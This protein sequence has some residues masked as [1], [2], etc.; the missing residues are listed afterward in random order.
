VIFSTLLRRPSAAP[1]RKKR[2]VLSD[3]GTLSVTRQRSRRYRI[4]VSSGLI[5]SVLLHILVVRLS[6][7]LVRYLED[8]AGIYRV[9]RPIIVEPR[10]MQAIEIRITEAPPVEPE[11]TPEPEPEPQAVEPEPEGAESSL[12]GAERLRPRVGDWR[13]WVV[14][15]LARRLDRT[16][17]E[18]N[19]ELEARLHAL[20]EAYDDSIAAEF[21]RAAESMDWTVGEEGN[22][23]G[24]SPQGL[25][26]GP[27]T[28]PLPFYIGPGRESEEMLRDYGAI[29]RQAGEDAIR[30][31]QKERIEAI[32]ER[33][34]QAR[35]EA[36]RNAQKDTTGTH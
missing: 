3:R 18:R 32:R 14:P 28:L 33:N 24:V 13:L 22:K 7:L 17:E 34:R 36:Q 10:G 9:P 6:P 23:W 21:A 27:V 5:L 25:H 4:A 16:P 8:D 20:L 1:D 11:R 30:D 31:A 26:L 29:Q 15:A 12:T 35:E 2:A 19:Q